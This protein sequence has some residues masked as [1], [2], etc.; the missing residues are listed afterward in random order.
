MTDTQEAPQ[1]GRRRGSR[2]AENR[3]AGRSAVEQLPPNQPR[4]PFEPMKVI[5]NDEIEAIA[6]V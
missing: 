1:R 2:R 3:A 6:T 4:I 5:S